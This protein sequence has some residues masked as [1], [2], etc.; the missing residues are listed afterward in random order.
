MVFSFGATSDEVGVAVEVGVVEVCG[1]GEFV[2]RE[3]GV[4][5]DRASVSKAA[6]LD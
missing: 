5:V 6:G 2:G 1:S 4:S 3:S